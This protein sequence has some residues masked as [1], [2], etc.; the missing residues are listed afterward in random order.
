MKTK[1]KSAKKPAKLQ[2][3]KATKDVKGGGGFPRSTLSRLAV[4][5]N[6]TF[7]WVR[8]RERVR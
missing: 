3:L 7:L 8:D 2:D 6:E 1:S 5:H 4:N